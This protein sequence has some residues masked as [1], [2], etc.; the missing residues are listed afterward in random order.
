MTL[1]AHVSGVPIEETLGMYGPALLL[2]L[3]AVSAKA[4]ARFRWPH[5]GRESERAA[6][7]SD[8]AGGSAWGRL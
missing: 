4:R 6:R 2:I 3:G 8:R 7:K 5:H 1:I